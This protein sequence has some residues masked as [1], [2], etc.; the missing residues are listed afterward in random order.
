MDKT[1]AVVGLGNISERHFHAIEAIGGRV[2]TTY[3]VDRSRNPKSR[4]FEGVLQSQAEWVVLLTPNSL[5]LDQ[6]LACLRA[7]KKVIVEKPPVISYF[8]LHH[9]QSDDPVYTVSQLRF[10]SEIAYI[11]DHLPSEN[12]VVLNVVAHRD[13]IY[14]ANWRGKEDWSGGL[15]Y[16]IGIHYLDILTWLFGKCKQIEY[17]R[18]M[19]KWKC[20]GILH[21]E[22]ATVE[23]NIEVSETK[24]NEKT[25]IINEE[26]VDLADGFFELHDE[27]YKA[28]M[29]GEGLKP[30]DL[31]Q[32]TKIIDQLISKK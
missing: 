23:F 32:C 30:W 29:R 20:Q 18:W 1:F 7:G 13:P 5:H 11:K 14:L 27:V 22:K 31:A 9:F 10:N 8:D 2:V 3:D 24:E 21:L 17:V 12:N 16:T 25:L 4:S 19:G 26:R 15:L 6:A 28:I